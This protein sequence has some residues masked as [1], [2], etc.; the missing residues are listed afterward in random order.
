M[1]QNFENASQNRESAVDNAP[2][3]SSDGQAEQLITEPSAESFAAP[4]NPLDN[5]NEQTE[6]NQNQEQQIQAE[7]PQN[8]KGGQTSAESISSL[9]QE[10]QIQKLL[11]LAFEKGVDK[12]V[13]IAKEMNNPAL[14]DGFHDAIMDNP[15]LKAQ[16]EAMGKI[17][18]L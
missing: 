7:I 4:E 3:E 14:Q 1:D 9:P 8:N 13:A 16:L 17:E 12:A 15:E 5:Q 2:S 6:Q 10:E 18:K 11:S